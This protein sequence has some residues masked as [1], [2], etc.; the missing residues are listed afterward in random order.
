[1]KKFL[2]LLC[3]SALTSLLYADTNT[4]NSVNQ[5]SIGDEVQSVAETNGASQI[6]ANDEKASGIVG[7]LEFSQASVD[8][9]PS[10]IKVSQKDF[11]QVGADNVADALRRTQ[12]VYVRDA[13]GGDPVNRLYMRGLDKAS[14]L[15]D[16]IPMVDVYRRENNY[17]FFATQG[18]ESIELAKGF[19]VPA[20]SAMGGGDFKS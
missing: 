19:I 5:T 7:E 18:I 9:N 12:G 14:I 4:T 13:I 8:D 15:I 11:K 10:L 16:G 2:S 17:I 1:M 3:L 20:Y 6:T